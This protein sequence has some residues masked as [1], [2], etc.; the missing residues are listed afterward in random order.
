MNI[1]HIEQLWK[2]ASNDP[3]HDTNWFDPVVV[4]FARLVMANNPPQSSMAWQEGYE[5]GKTAQNKE[6]ESLREFAAGRRTIQSVAAALGPMSLWPKSGF[7]RELEKAK[8]E[9]R[10]RILKQIAQLHDSLSLASDPSGLRAR[11]QS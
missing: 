3:N 8:A 4:E 7:E 9:E 1:R 2:Q 5:A 11:N 10:E 6:L